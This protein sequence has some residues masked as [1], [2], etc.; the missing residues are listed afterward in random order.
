MLSKPILYLIAAVVISGIVGGW[1]WSYGNKKWHEGYSK[2]EAEY[3]EASKVHQEKVIN[4]LPK[5]EKKYAKKIKTV[6]GSDLPVGPAT[7]T[8]LDSLREQWEADR[9]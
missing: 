8:A 6:Q 3:S 7:A 9:R 1:L 4:E 2:C 5:V